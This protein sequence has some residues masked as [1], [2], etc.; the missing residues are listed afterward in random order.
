MFIGTTGSN[1][2]NADGDVVGYARASMRQPCSQHFLAKGFGQLGCLV[3]LSIRQD[4]GKLLSAITGDEISDPPKHHLEQN[5]D[6]AQAVIPGQVSVTVIVGFEE[7]NIAENKGKG[8][9][10]TTGTANFCI[11]HLVELP[12]IGHSG[13][14]IFRG[15][16][17]QEYCFFQHA[18]D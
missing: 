15:P 18:P 3:S 13:Q 17:I 8:L 7:S 4:N 9:A 2:T 11:Q 14:T 5:A 12:P 6:V 16:V 10:G 1:H